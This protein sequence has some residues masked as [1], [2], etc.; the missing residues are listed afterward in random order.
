[1]NRVVRGIQALA[2]A[3]LS[4]GLCAHADTILSTVSTVR[5]TVAP[6][7]GA[8]SITDQ[9]YLAFSFSLANPYGD[10][11]IRF[12]D[13]NF[14]FANARFW[15]TNALGPTATSSNVIASSTFFG[16]GHFNHPSEFNPL[17]GLTLGAGTYF[18]IFSS[19]FCDVGTDAHCRTQ[20]GLLGLGETVLIDAVA[21]VT[22]NGGF[23]TSDALNCHQSGTCQIDFDF[24]PASLWQ[25][26]GDPHI[27][28]P[29]F[30]VAG[31]A[32]PEPESIALLGAGLAIMALTARLKKRSSD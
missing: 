19:P 17:S 11:S 30:E 5:T 18:M 14:T 1:M 32:I 26:P 6:F 22:Y 27:D 3:W 25:G 28:G 24:A 9:Q 16:N 8:A 21:G 31:K 13:L 12:H 10:V 4:A 23:V 7:S 29:R 15:L 2:L 20:V